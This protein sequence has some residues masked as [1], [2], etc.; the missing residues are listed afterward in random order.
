MASPI[1]WTWVWVNSGSWW[2]TGRPGVLGFMGS[3]RV[4]HDWATELNWTDPVPLHFIFLLLFFGQIG[5]WS[6][7]RDWT[8]V[9]YIGST[10]LNSGLPGKPQLSHSCLRFVFSRPDILGFLHQP[11]FI[12]LI[13]SSPCKMWYLEPSCLITADQSGPFPS[14]IQKMPE[15]ERKI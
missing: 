4:G 10:V 13:V 5:M 14:L 7:I 6:L 2:W 1:W 8:H 12:F 9:P 15:V 11:T 3:Q